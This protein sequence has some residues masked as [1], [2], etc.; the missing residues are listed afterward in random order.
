MIWKYRTVLRKQASTVMFRNIA[1]FV[2]AKRACRFCLELFNRELVALTGYYIDEE[3][4]ERYE[5][6]VAVFRCRPFV[7][8]NSLFGMNLSMAHKWMDFDFSVED[9][10]LSTYFTKFAA[11][12]NVSFSTDTRNLKIQFEKAI[13]GL[14]SGYGLD[15]TNLALDQL[16]NLPESEP[17][18]ELESASESE[19]ESESGSEFE[20]EEVADWD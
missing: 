2:I 13:S 17:E 18:Y 19:S 6:R 8:A 16:R 10:V 20:S 7:E 12:C 11:A 3:G 9:F 14:D 4:D 15:I 5:G 1:K